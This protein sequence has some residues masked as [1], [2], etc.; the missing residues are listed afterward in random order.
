M[1]EVEFTAVAEAELIGA[2]NYLR[3][4]AGQ[5]VAANWLRRILQAVQS[6][7]ALPERCGRAAEADTTGQ[8]ARE[9]LFDRRRNTFRIVF[10]IRQNVV[11]IRH[12]RRAS[13]GPVP[14]GQ[15]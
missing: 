6:L 14:P 11:W 1:F 8:D 13:R 4:T 15:F 5:V 2:F 7:R 9:L 12:I 10:V 3:R